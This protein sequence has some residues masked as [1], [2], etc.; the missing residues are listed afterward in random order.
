MKRYTINGFLIPV[1][2]REDEKVKELND[3]L[4]DEYIKLHTNEASDVETTKHEVYDYIYNLYKAAMIAGKARRIDN[5]FVIHTNETGDGYIRKDV[6][7][8]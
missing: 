8:L 1:T 2:K 6:P 7:I 3:R 4:Y 5:S